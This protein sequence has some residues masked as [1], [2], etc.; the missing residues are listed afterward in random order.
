MP[1]QLGD[2]IERAKLSTDES[3]ML[4]PYTYNQL[5]E[6]LPEEEQY[7]FTMAL[8]EL[9]IQTKWAAFSKSEQA[10][11]Q[12]FL[13]DNPEEPEVQVVASFADRLAKAAQT[14]TQ[15]PGGLWTPESWQEEEEY[16]LADEDLEPVDEEYE[17][18]AAEDI[19]EETQLEEFSTY[20]SDEYVQQ[21]R[22]VLE[23]EGIA[24]DADGNVS[25]YQANLPG[26]YTEQIPMKPMP[27]DLA[28]QKY[29]QSFTA[30]EKEQG[31][32]KTLLDAVS[33]MTPEMN[34]LLE[35]TDFL[36]AM[37]FS[38]KSKNKMVQT[39]AT[40]LE[41]LNQILTDPDW[42]KIQPLLDELK[43]NLETYTQGY[44]TQQD[45]SYEVLD[46][47]DR[48]KDLQQ[49]DPEKFSEAVGGYGALAAFRKRQQLD[50]PHIHVTIG[51][52]YIRQRAQEENPALRGEMLEEE[53]QEWSDYFIKDFAVDHI[54]GSDTHAYL[55][56]HHILSPYRADYD[57]VLTI[58]VEPGQGLTI[59]ADNFQNLP[60]FGESDNA[61][62]EEEV[63]ALVERAFEGAYE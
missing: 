12:E 51:T 57:E 30:A 44:A 6:A 53:A 59:D 45:N 4:A 15:S 42:H 18:V 24:I 17:E 1:I 11:M 25:F 13:E 41:G 37:K 2:A 50:L 31:K 46:A 63:S 34:D 32:V 54:P 28:Y 40:G 16:E 14:F 20:E 26:I 33:R 48:L 55:T 7:P 21:I 19:I 35:T 61:V 56:E 49:N 43:G 39:I 62:V 3:G 9:G 52:D 47:L 8:V 27:L 23:R 58:L 22:D 10:E 29:Y 36:A 60:G 5:I 38:P